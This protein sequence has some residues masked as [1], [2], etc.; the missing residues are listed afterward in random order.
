MRPTLILPV[1]EFCYAVKS[2]RL[3]AILE[4]AYRDAVGCS[5]SQAER[6]S[7]NGSLPR[8]SGLLELCELSDSVLVGLEVQLP[9]YSERIDAVLYGQGA[10]GQ[11]SLVLIELKQWSNVG[12]STDGR[13]TIMMRNGPVQVVHPSLQVDGYRRHLLNFARAFHNRPGVQIAGCV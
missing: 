9:Y 1:R 11:A 3:F 7:W 4:T 6:A 2:N 5:V 8:L 10:G 12:S 13:L